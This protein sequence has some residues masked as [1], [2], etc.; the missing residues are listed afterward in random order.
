MYVYRGIPYPHSTPT[1]GDRVSKN[2]LF[3]AHCRGINSIGMPLTH[4]LVSKCA[5]VCVN[6]TTIYAALMKNTAYVIDF[7]FVTA[8][9]M[10]PTR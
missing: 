9:S 5:I 7:A 10:F 3:H 4:G 6:Y 2:M 1:K 8:S